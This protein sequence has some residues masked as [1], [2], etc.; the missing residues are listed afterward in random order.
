MSAALEN[1]PRG[2]GEL[3]EV[4]SLAGAVRAWQALDGELQAEAVLTPERAVTLDGESVS[5]FS[6]MAIRDLAARLDGEEPEDP[7]EAA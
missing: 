4:T 3:P 5:A 1:V 7:P 6:G 2:G